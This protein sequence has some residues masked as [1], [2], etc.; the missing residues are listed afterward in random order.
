MGQIPLLLLPT[1]KLTREYLPVAAPIPCVAL[2]K[3]ADECLVESNAFVF[4]W[5]RQ[6]LVNDRDQRA[7]S[8][9]G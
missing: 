6:R 8:E 4:D 3:E 1:W 2:M 7:E 9:S 5:Q